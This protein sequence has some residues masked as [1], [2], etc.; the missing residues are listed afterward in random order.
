MD[1]KLIYDDSPILVF[2]GKKFA[3]LICCTFNP[4]N[5]VLSK[6]ACFMPGKTEVER[7]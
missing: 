1:K 3:L 6:W 5:L 2:P 7:S 4:T